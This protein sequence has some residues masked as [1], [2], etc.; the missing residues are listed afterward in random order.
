MLSKKERKEVFK[1]IFVKTVE[2]ILAIRAEQKYL[3]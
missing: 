3:S 2:A 1:H